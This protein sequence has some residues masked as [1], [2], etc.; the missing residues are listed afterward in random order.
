[1]DPREVS[2]TGRVICGM[3]TLGRRSGYDIKQFVDKTT[4]HFMAVSYGQLYPELKRLEQVG[5]VAGSSAPTGGRSRTFYELTDE[6]RAALAQ[7]LDSDEELLYELRDEGMLKLFFSD[8]RPERRIANLRALRGR[9]ERKLAELRA[10][11]PMASAGVRQGPRLTL[12]LGIGMAEWIIQWC[13]ATEHR[14]ADEQED[15]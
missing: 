4:R 12:E 10:L 11:E 2:L 9:N 13:E 8:A 1:M 3:I 15:Q 7:W 14:L 5:L 6:G